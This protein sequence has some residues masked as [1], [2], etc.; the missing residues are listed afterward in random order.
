M[1]P[2]ESYV[3]KSNSAENLNKETLFRKFNVCPPKHK[4]CTDKQYCIERKKNLRFKNTLK[5][6]L[7]EQH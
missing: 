3:R 6:D 1:M 5:N 2:S 7:K 4:P